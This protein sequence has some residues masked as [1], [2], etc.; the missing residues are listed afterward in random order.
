MGLFDWLAKKNKP[1]SQMT[2]QEL[3]QQELLLQK[4]R[5]LMLKRMEKLGKEKQSLFDRGAT[6]KMPE[7]RRTLAQE[8]DLKTTEQLMIGRQLNVRSKEMLTV[9]RFRMLRENTER[10]K[11]SGDRLGLVSEKDLMSLEKLIESDAVTSEMYQ[12]RLDE[13]LE[14]GAAADAGQTGLSASGQQVMDMWDQMDRGL[15]TDKAEAFDEADRR[16]RER[17]AEM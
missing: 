13:M 11:Q 3:R 5:D 7:V 16:V 15:V 2:R 6:E 1:L 10:A 4:E 17:Q 9:S 8:F 12:Q 14:I